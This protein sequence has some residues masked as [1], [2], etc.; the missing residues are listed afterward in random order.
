MKWYVYREHFN[1]HEIEVFDVFRHISFRD[2]TI[3][4]KKKNLGKDEFSKEL[5]SIAMYYFWSKCEYE[6]VITSWPPYID[7]AELQRLNKEDPAY[8][9]NVRLSVGRKVDVYQQL[10]LNWDRFVD[11]V[12]DEV[13]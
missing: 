11:Y 13:S 2:N 7:N 4:L 5:K 1:S 8:E 12:Y 6:V 10:E 3:N 9:Q